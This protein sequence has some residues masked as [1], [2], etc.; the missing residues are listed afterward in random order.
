MANEASI[1]TV[2]TKFNKELDTILDFIQQHRGTGKGVYVIYIYDYA[3]IKTFKDFE[4]L[5]LNTIVG[6]ISQEAPYIASPAGHKGTKSVKKKDAENLFIGNKYFSFKGP[7]GLLKQ[8]KTF[9]PTNHWFI[10]ILSDTA[11]NKTFD[12]LIPLR[13]FAAHS[14]KTA[15]KN[16]INAVGFQQLG[17]SGAWL[18]VGS[19]FQNII[20]DLKDIAARINAQ[21]KF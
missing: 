1:K 8:I 20:D 2:V 19:R 12:V 4:E 13:N 5:L 16:A 14:S 21:A 15:K 18:K 3:V 11:Y 17:N 9:F 10:S 6:L 7:N